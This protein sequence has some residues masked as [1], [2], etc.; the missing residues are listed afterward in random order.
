MSSE[1]GVRTAEQEAGDH[2]RARTYL[3]I[4]LNRLR[5]LLDCA[6]DPSG[7]L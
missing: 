7:A 6:P 2:T 5:R 1:C 4:Y 3:S